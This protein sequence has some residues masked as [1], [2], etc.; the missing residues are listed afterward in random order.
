MAKINLLPWRE[1]LRKQRQQDFLIALGGSVLLTCILFGLVYL[2]IEGMKEY[3][4][5]RNDMV[6][7]EIDD[8]MKK[9]KEIEDIEKKKETLNTKID[10]I[11]GLQESRPK[12]VRV[13]DELRKI[14]PVGVHLVSVDQKGGDIT[15][16]GKAETNAKVSDYMKAVEGSQWLTAPN[17]KFV[18]G[19][20][21]QEIKGQL[22]DFTLQ[23]KQKEE[24]KEEKKQ[25]KAAENKPAETTGAK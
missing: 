7:H 1:D 23:V 10:L 21:L 14:T 5:K 22:K 25:E 13:F 17:L 16:T 11:K 20:G 15:I 18:K 6:Q 2:H 19:F 9:I 24:K 8:V 12:I 3:Q 4:Q